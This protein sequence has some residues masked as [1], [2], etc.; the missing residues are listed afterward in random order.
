MLSI[1]VYSTAIFNLFFSLDTSRFESF[2][3]KWEQIWPSY[4]M[5]V[6][7][8]GRGDG[9]GVIPGAAERENY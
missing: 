3:C 1:T 8:R 2:L 9:G 6:W 7:E 4:E 5:C